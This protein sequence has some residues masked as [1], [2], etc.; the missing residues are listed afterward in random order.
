M[1]PESLPSEKSRDATTSGSIASDGRT[2]LAVNRVIEFS[3]VMYP[4]E[5]HQTR[6]GALETRLPRRDDRRTEVVDD[7]T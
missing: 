5:S 2:G 7:G 1:K 3:F 6:D 4:R